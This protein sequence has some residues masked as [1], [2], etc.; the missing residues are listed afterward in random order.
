[1]KMFALPFSAA[2]LLGLAAL[3]CLAAPARAQ[4]AAPHLGLKT[5]LNLAT[6]TGG[7]YLSRQVDWKAGLAAGLVATYPLAASSGLQAEL[8]YSQKGV[9]QDNYTYS[10]AAGRPASGTYLATLGYL[11]VPVLYTFG[12]GSGGRPGAFAE[13]GPQV[14]V[15][16]HKREAVHLVTDPLGGGR[17]ELLDTEVRSLAP[18]SAGYVAGLGYQWQNGLGA[19]LRYSGDFTRVY[20]SG[21]GSGYLAAGSSNQLHNGV[22][23][24]QLRYLFSKGRP[25]SPASQASSARPLPPPVLV[26]DPA[27][28]R[29]V[30]RVLLVA[31]ILSWFNWQCGPRPVCQPAG[32]PVFGRSRP[33]YQPGPV[34]GRPV[35]S[36]Q[37]PAG[38]LPATGPVLR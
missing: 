27:E 17:D 9:R 2:S 15:A 11:D 25:A 19:E 29:T 21:Y 31:S 22:L 1:M 26:L 3:L 16:L 8:L 32:R 12:A 10:S 14:S 28:E 6:Y 24:F 13:V 18:L 23:Q 5:S 34:L 35:W 36:P 37:L 38:R 4:L 33:V 20:R 7:G 30:H